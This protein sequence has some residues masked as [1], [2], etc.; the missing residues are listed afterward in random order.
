MKQ[1]QNV[2]VLLFKLIRKLQKLVLRSIVFNRLVVLNLMRLITGFIVLYFQRTAINYV[3][4][5]NLDK[6][7]TPVRCTF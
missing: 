5:P 1:K 3:R 2:V 4:K 6:L 7:F